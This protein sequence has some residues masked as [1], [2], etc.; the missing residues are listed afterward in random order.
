MGLRRT[1]I[2][3][4]QLVWR[5]YQGAVNKGSVGGGHKVELDLQGICGS[6]P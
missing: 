5:C 3:G 1:A 2:L 6:A 4:T